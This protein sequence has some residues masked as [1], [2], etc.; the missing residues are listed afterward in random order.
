MA[1]SVARPMGTPGKLVWIL[2]VAALWALALFFVP[3]GRVAGFFAAYGTTSDGNPL[4]HFVPQQWE[5]WVMLGAAVLAM[6][7][8]ALAARYGRMP[9]IAWVGFPLGQLALLA[10][11]TLPH[12]LQQTLLFPGIPS[13]L[14]SSDLPALLL[15]ATAAF[16]GSRVAPNRRFA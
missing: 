16:A 13:L 3:I 5:V 7:I 14:V 10:S 15:V 11:V 6:V 1:E 12:G 2:G 8:T 4:V 9:A